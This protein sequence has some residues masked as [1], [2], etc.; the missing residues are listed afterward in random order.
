MADKK[1]VSSNS[2]KP[3]E[4]L[5]KINELLSYVFI[6][7][8]KLDLLY[9]KYSQVPCISKYIS[10]NDRI[11]KK[12]ANDA[13]KAAKEAVKVKKKQQYQQAKEGKLPL[14]Y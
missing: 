5:T 12:A 2:F 14:Q 9:F 11:R 10:Q 8:L 1:E 13:K 6:D 3:S 7:L 4:E